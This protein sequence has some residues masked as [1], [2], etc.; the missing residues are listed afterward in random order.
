MTQ[1]F[2]M[3][4]CVWGGD[5]KYNDSGIGW[6]FL[7]YIET[8]QVNNEKLRAVIK[9]KT[10]CKSQRIFLV[11]FKEALTSCNGLAEKAEDQAQD[12]IFELAKLQR[13]LKF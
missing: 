2:E 9:L 13:E 4:V 6:L 1:A 3:C 8:V 11:A 7:K 5:E 12:L 10:R